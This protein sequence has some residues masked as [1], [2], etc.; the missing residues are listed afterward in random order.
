MK[1]LAIPEDQEVDRFIIKPVIEALFAD[2][3]LPARVD[4]LPEPRLRGASEALDPS[5]I[6]SIVEDNPMT[7]L[8]VLM[9][10]R[11][12]NRER[13]EERALARQSEHPGR[14]LACVA[15][16]ELE[17]WMLA[18]HA[19]RIGAPWGTVR[20]ECDPKE[21][22]AEPLLKQIGSEGPG[23]GRKRAMQALAGN[24]RSLRSRCPELQGLQDAVRNFV[25]RRKTG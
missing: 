20:Q 21:R 16:Q 19:E 9:I 12:C 23:R 18:L 25:E 1:V 2:L 8:F 7:D 4:V 10:D 11:D 3:Q 24:W 13:N 15:V 22:W 6:R 14:V 17:V 5:M